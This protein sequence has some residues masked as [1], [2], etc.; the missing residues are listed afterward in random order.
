MGVWVHFPQ[1]LSSGGGLVGFL[2]HFLGVQIP[3]FTHGCR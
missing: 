1:L 2:E 3:T